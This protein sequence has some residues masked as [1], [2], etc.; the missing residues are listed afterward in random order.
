LKKSLA[1][2]STP[3]GLEIAL[4]EDDKLVEFHQDVIVREFMVGDIYLGKVKKILPG[5]NA[6]FVDIGH[7]KQG[8]LH[9]HDLGPDFRTFC[10]FTKKVIENKNIDESISQFQN[11]PEIFKGGDIGKV[12]EIDL[13]VM[14]QLAKEPI[15][16]KG[17]RLS[18]EIAIAGKYIVLLPFTQSIS[19]S[20]RIRDKKER[21]RLNTIFA[22][23]TTKNFGII[24]RT[25][26]ESKPAY[27]LEK[28]LTFVL[29]RWKELVSN[30][31]TG[32]S[33]LLGEFSKATSIIRE[34][35][36][37]SF[38]SIVVDDNDTYNELDDYIE[39]VSPEQKKILRLYKDSTPLFEALNIDRQVKSLFGR[40]INF[41]KGSYLVIEHTEAMTVVDVNSG[42]KSSRDTD[43]E[44]TMLNVNLD[45]ADEIARQLRLRDIGGLIVVDFIDMRSYDNQRELF[46]RMKNA[47]KNDRAQ[48]SV[49]PLSKFGLMEITRERVKPAINIS[50]AETCPVCKGSGEIKPT[51][52][53]IDDIEHSLNYIASETKVNYIKLKVH[54][55][56]HSFLKAGFYPIVLRWMLK[57]RMWISLDSSESLHLI[58]YRLLDGKGN[59]LEE[60]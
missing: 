49:L 6:A 11:L 24:I 25:A 47:L 59:D 30:L 17:H 3:E 48:H 14:V 45:A 38:D 27:I 1:I 18:A 8:F 23:I 51:I 31:A 9:Y 37:D 53:V 42:S 26:A 15:S 13:P 36:N 20:K 41:G 52:I 39:Q 12:I 21:K 44:E 5:L 28:D 2:Q 32:K 54:P 40:I 46:E 60:F 58:D 19:I 56:V 10:K 22:D 7:E 57:F 34:L 16:T 33:K 50:I 43:R 29:E 4:L 55:F 35:L